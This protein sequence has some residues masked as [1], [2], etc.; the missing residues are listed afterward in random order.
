MSTVYDDSF[1]DE[2]YTINS[3]DVDE[4]YQE[5][6]M[7]RS[8][9]MNALKTNDHSF[10]GEDELRQSVAQFGPNN[11]LGQGSL[12]QRIFGLLTSQAKNNDETVRRSA[13][14]RKSL[15]A[16]VHSKRQKSKTM[17]VE[18]IESFVDNAHSK[19]E[20][21]LTHNSINNENSLC[22]S[23]EFSAKA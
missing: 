5:M 21:M 7:K 8:S 2:E 9:V 22:H 16:S 18:S 17:G 3:E 14:I 20:P 23:N 6:M 10:V 19:E 4:Q 1:V 15:K 13:S 11:A 12:D